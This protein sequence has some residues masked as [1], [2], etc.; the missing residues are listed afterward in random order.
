MRLKD[1][2]AIV[3]GAGRGIGKAIA[4]RFAKEGA[5]VVVDDVNDTL[6]TD[7]VS[8][9]HDA[10]GEAI[11]LNA[12]VSNPTAADALISKTVHTY[13]TVD[14]LVN[15]AICS[16]EDVLNNNWEANLSVALQGTSHCSNAVV[17]IM[18]KGNGGSIVNIASV[19]GL[20]GLQGIHAYSAAKGGVIALTRSM[21]V[22]HGADNIR[23]NCICPGTVQTEVWEPMIERNPN[24]LDEITPWYP[25][26][27]IGK[28]MDIA[29]AALFLAS[30]EASFATG[31]VFVIDGGLTAGNHQFP[32]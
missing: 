19:N 24:I 23:V 15:N 25:L 1:K 10:V 9:I 22:A 16:T 11:F 5:K 6:G 27:R 31:A 32:I 8:I 14:I 28:P 21:A 7:T 12:D 2:T 20:I 30:D 17:P 29:N 13:R 18:Q 4:I 3:T 26:G